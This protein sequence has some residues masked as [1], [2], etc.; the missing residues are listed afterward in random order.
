MHPLTTDL[1]ALRRG[2][3]VHTT[4]L[5]PRLGPALRALCAVTDNDDDVT[6]RDKV[7]TTLTELA[8]RLPDD[9]R[10]CFTAAFALSEQTR[11]PFYADRLTWAGTE[12]KRE[13]RTIRRRV[14]EGITSVAQL[15]TT[16]PRQSWHTDELHAVV[17]LAGTPEVFEFRRVIADTDLTEITLGW[18]TKTGV[19]DLAIAVVHG[20]TLVE[21]TRKSRN[22]VAATVRLPAPLRAGQPHTISVRLHPDPMHPLYVCTPHTP[23]TT[24][25]LRVVFPPPRFPTHALLLDG[26]L[27]AE[28]DDDL[29]SHPP[30]PIDA[31]GQ[32]A[33]TF[34]NLTPHLSYGVRW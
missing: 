16:R 22:R 6:A 11:Q 3:A 34:T 32:I 17:S 15:A 24:F 2:R 28:V 29:T 12:L 19:E 9:L 7:I 23:C 4:P 30:I 13:S 33:T 20:G 27:P 21:R 14:D 25:S 5:P 31:T 1:K 10:L 26:V 18:S 8:G